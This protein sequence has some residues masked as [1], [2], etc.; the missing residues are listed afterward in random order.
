MADRI[1]LLSRAIIQNLEDERAVRNT[2]PDRPTEDRAAIRQLVQTDVAALQSDLEVRNARSSAT[3][4][5]AILTP[6]L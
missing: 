2:L 4:L 6:S 3:F 5:I 1:T